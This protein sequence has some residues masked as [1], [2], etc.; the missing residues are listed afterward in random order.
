MKKKHAIT[1]SA[2]TAIGNRITN[3]DNFFISE[4]K[5]EKQLTEK[6]EVI[7]DEITDYYLA[8]VADGIGGKDN[9]ADAAEITLNELLCEKDLLF[10]DP[11]ELWKRINDK[12]LSFSEENNISSG[13]TL[14]AAVVYSNDADDLFATVYYIGDSGVLVFDENRKLKQEINFKRNTASIFC[15]SSYICDYIGKEYE[16]V[17]VSEVSF[18][19]SKGDKIIL[20][21]D[22]AEIPTEVIGRNLEASG[23]GIADRIVKKAVAYHSADF[24]VADNATSVVIEI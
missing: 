1:V 9:G 15:T 21:T 17:P 11:A 10:S 7:S 5:V 8:A 12:V 22:G 13:C 24:P 14:T 6:S 18:S 3:D 20:M 19:V 23:N 2:A 4:E 16:N